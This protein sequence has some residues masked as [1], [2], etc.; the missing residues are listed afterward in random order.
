MSRDPATP[1]KARS[2]GPP[3]EEHGGPVRVLILEDTPSDAELMKRMLTKEGLDFAPLR[4]QDRDS[5]RKALEN[6]NP[7]IILADYALPSFDGKE[8]L[9]LA[10]QLTPHVPFLFVSRAMGEERAIDSLR[11]GATDYVLKNHLSR[12]GPSVRRA[13]EEAAEQRARREAERALRHSEETHRVLLRINN[14]VIQKLDKQAVFDATVDSFRQ[15]IP[16]DRASL[17]LLDPD[18]STLRVAAVAKE[19]DSPAWMDVGAE[20]SVEGS[21]LERVVQVPEPAVCGDLQHEARTEIQRRLLARG[22]RSYVAVPLQGHRGVVGTL[23]FGSMAPY[24]YAD[25]DLAFLWATCEQIGL[26]VENMLAYEEIQELHSRLALE[27][28]FL[29]EEV[30]RAKAFGEILGESEAIRRVQRAVDQVAPTDATVLITGESGTGKE[31][32]AREVHKRSKRASGPMIPVNCAAIPNEL[33]ESEFFG[34]VK[35]AFSGASRDRAGRFEAAEGGTLFLDEV[36]EIPVELQ[37]KLLRVLEDRAYERIGEERTRKADVRIIA[38]SNRDLDEEVA[39]GRFR[40]DLYYRLNVFPIHVPPLRERRD[41]IPILA[42]HFLD[43]ATRKLDRQPPRLT[44]EIVARLQAYAWPG[45]VR[46]LQNVMER[47]VIRTPAG[48]RLKLDL[49]PSMEQVPLESTSPGGG[50]TADAL[51]PDR[52]LTDAE[53][54]ELEKAN[55]LRALEATD[56]QVYGEGGAAELLDVPPST[57]ASRIKRL[58]ISN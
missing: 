18:G 28:T 51:P 55:I 14:A 1:Q 8:A 13:L 23:N 31:L 26:A 11:R 58:G 20:F 27:T 49:H 48:G 56:G 45:N 10:L 2:A 41:D 37:S 43:M 29:R 9:E 19:D 12:L 46:E 50:F 24:R 33:Y 3:G 39:E 57:L 30:D 47:A 32:V 54:T 44:D 38:A 36:G 6:W 7:D 5:F 17:V 40:Q 4:V 42:A 35:G 52:I 53:F 15:L 21:H 34:H 22:I 25:V 16:F